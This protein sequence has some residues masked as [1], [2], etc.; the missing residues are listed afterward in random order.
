M[1]KELAIAGFVFVLLLTATVV[2][3][4]KANPLPMPMVSIDSPKN[5][6]VYPSSTVELHFT[7]RP[8][9]YQNFMSL[10]YVLD[11]QP[12]K[13]TNG[14]TTL[15]DLPS[16]SH[17]LTVYVTYTYQI[18]NTTYETKDAIGAIVYFSTQY[19]TAWVTITIITLSAATLI[20]SLLFFKRRQIATRLRCKKRDTF[21]VGTAFLAF[22]VLVFVSFTWQTVK[23]YLFPY[24]PRSM[25]IFPPSWLVLIV[26]L[27]FMGMGLSMMTSGTKKSQPTVVKIEEAPE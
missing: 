1:N 6:E 24:W 22:G 23:D 18:G 3:V 16:G 20:P 9:S 2:D 7:P 27:T 26:A 19:S 10:T 12:P 14:T 25:L 4:A 13:A 5:N 17:I 11:G 15:T 21:W 8:S